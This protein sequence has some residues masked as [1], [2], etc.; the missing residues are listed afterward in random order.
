MSRI[1]DEACSPFHFR[2]SGPTIKRFQSGTNREQGREIGGEG[3]EEL[4]GTLVAQRV[5][6]DCPF[7]GRFE[8]FI[9]RRKGENF[10]ETK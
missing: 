9:R 3:E 4:D 5:S 2:R 1:A 10:K 7:Q 6:E 8:E